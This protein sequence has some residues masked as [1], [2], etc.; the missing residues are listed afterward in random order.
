MNAKHLPQ[1]L[2]ALIAMIVLSAGQAQAQ[3]GPSVFDVFDG[4]Y[5]Q[6]TNST[7][8]PT[9]PIPTELV[10]LSLTGNVANPPVVQELPDGS[11]HVD[12]FFDIT[13]RIGPQGGPY[14]IDSFFDV[15]TEISF[16]APTTSP[17]GLVTEADAQILSMGLPP[18]GPLRLDAI[19]EHRG[20]VTVLKLQD[21]GGGF[22][23]D[24]FFDVFTELSVDGGQDFVPAANPTRLVSSHTIVPEPATWTLT[25]VVVLACG[26]RR[27]R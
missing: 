23:I 20:H 21:P 22:Q 11:F 17:D 15:W 18:T 16:D 6:S 9:T 7:M 12:S 26:S 10:E 27:K 3:N 13:Y 24:S 14:T 1:P 2:V 4:L 19:H 25:A 8:Y 5:L